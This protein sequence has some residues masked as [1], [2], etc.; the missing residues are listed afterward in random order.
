V[1]EAVGRPNEPLY[2][3]ATGGYTALKR[4]GEPA[5]I[6]ERRG[7]EALISWFTARSKLHAYNLA[8]KGRADEEG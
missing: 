3:A 8:Q 5:A 2:S 1:R 6:Y 7:S 4:R